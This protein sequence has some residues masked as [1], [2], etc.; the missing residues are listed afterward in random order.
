MGS[1]IEN[2][3]HYLANDPAQGMTGLNES[4]YISTSLG[5]L[6]SHTDLMPAGEGLLS[7]PGVK[8]P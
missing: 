7:H 3:V 6:C 2:T 4:K 5:C 8:L 1:L